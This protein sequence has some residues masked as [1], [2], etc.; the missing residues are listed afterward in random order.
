M[1]FFLSVTFVGC[2]SYLKKKR[3][4]NLKTQY[5]LNLDVKKATVSCLFY[6]SVNIP[7]RMGYRHRQLYQYCSHQRNRDQRHRHE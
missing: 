2:Y 6:F 1:F 5:N 4:I 3:S 7:I